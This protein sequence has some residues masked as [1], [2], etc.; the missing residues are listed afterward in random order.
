LHYHLPCPAL[1]LKRDQVL[2]LVSPKCTCL[3]NASKQTKV[4]ASILLDCNILRPCPTFGSSYLFFGSSFLFLIFFYRFPPHSGPIP[5]EMAANNSHDFQRSPT[6][7]LSSRIDVSP[8]ASSSTEQRPRH[9]KYASID[10]TFRKTSTLPKTHARR[11]T[12]RDQPHA[13]LTPP[14]TPS[15]S[16][17]TTAGQDSAASAAVQQGRDLDDVG[18]K[19]EI[20]DPDLGSTRFLLVRATL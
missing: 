10:P 2:I 8:P 13:L 4:P 17:R 1:A 15:S 5:R 7:P 11:R 19:E 6:P 18:F 9:I 20:C 12:E 14:L 3:L 16:I